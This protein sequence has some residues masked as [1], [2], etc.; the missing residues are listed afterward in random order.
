MKRWGIRV[1]VVALAWYGVIFLLLPRL[2]DG[3]G[4]PVMPSLI[5]G[6]LQTHG[7]EVCNRHARL[8]DRHGSWALQ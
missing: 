1:A 5:R 2:I 7:S 6:S 3:G 4:D 8:G